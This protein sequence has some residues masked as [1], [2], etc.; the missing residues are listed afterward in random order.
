ML[1]QHIIKK[2]ENNPK[3]L[4]L[5]DGL[6]ALLSA[7]LVGFVLVQFKDYFGMPAN[8]LYLLAA[9][10]IVFVFFDMYC[11]L[12]KHKKTGIFLKMI[13]LLNLQYCMVSMGFAFYHKDTLTT[14]GWTYIFVE[15][16]ILLLLS[17]F[18][19]TVGKRL[20]RTS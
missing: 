17:A 3:K 5:I 20:T 1:F 4:F 10:P 6:G 12:K 2:A 13:A 11:Y 14:L 7:F 18:E 19:F 8:T 16:L 15:I 9:F